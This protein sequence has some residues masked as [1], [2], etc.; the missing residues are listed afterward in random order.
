MA[1]NLPAARKGSKASNKS[2]AEQFSGTAWVDDVVRGARGLDCVRAE[3]GDLSVI[4]SVAGGG[5]QGSRGSRV[6][7]TDL[8]ALA[9]RLLTYQPGSTGRVAGNTTA[10]KTFVNSIH[11]AEH[12]GVNSAFDKGYNLSFTTGTVHAKDG[13]VIGGYR[14]RGQRFINVYM[15]A[16]EQNDAGEVTGFDF[17]APTDVLAAFLAGLKQA[18]AKA[19]SA[20]LM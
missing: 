10:A 19:V 12:D 5:K 16:P 3:N 11:Y 17:L 15:G 4:L 8:P 18:Q 6:K 1:I 14:G 9:D 7:L 20:G 2:T 13:Q